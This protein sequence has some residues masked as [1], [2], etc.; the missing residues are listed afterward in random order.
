MSNASLFTWLFAILPLSVVAQGQGYLENPQPDS[1][2]SGIS[3]VSGEK[4]GTDHH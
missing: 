1:S 2:Q 3:V 4:M